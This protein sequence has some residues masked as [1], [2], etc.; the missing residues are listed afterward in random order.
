ME[1]IIGHPKN[2]QKTSVHNDYDFALL[3]LAQPIHFTRRTKPIA[4]PQSNDQIDVA[5]SCYVSGWG[6]INDL[7][8]SIF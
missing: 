6:A 8:L 7:F 4:L 5:T 3:K 2:V 1:R